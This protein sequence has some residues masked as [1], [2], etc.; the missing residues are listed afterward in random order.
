MIL[1]D[2]F[3]SIFYLG[4]YNSLTEINALSFNEFIL[5]TGLYLLIWW[6]MIKLFCWFFEEVLM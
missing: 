2:V 5:S 3:I 6:F 1:L 4:G